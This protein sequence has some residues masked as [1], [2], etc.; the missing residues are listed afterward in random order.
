MGLSTT[1]DV[2][3]VTNLENRLTADEAAMITNNNNN[4]QS[5][6][7]VK[8]TGQ[9]NAFIMD[10]PPATNGQWF[11][12]MNGDGTYSMAQGRF[13]TGSKAVELRS[14][15][16]N[17][18]IRTGRSGTATSADLNLITNDQGVA[19][20]S[21]N[22][23]MTPHAGGQINQKAQV[24]IYPLNDGTNGLKIDV[25]PTNHN[26]RISSLSATSS[27]IMLSFGHDNTLD[28]RN[29]ADSAWMPMLA[30]AFNVQSA[31]EYKENI[32]EYT[33]PVLEKIK[34]TP[35]RSYTLKHEK[36][37]GKQIGLVLDE[38]PE[39]LKENETLKLYQT[40]SY[41][42]KAVQELTAKLEELQA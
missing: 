27:D 29:I 16:D 3:R 4:Q 12:I 10:L 7:T 5:I 1:F 33:E 25:Q 41:L 23:N 19:G 18:T 13:S 21:Q 17:F 2:S 36:E 14:Y 15:Y 31:R 11:G 39:E 42:W 20:I 22:I 8:I 9:T 32:E 24:N 26:P 34:K 37:R 40:V 38:V 35:V 30:S 6:S 28:V